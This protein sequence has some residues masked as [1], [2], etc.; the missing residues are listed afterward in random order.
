VKNIMYSGLVALSL[1]LSGCGGGSDEASCRF[2]VQQNLDTGNFDAVITELS[3][4]NSACSNSYVEN[5]LQID[6]GAAYMGQAG[7]GITDIIT[8]LTA[9]SAASSPST[10][11]TLIDK[12]SGAQSDTVLVSLSN[13]KKAYE[14]ALG[15]STCAN[16][17]L[18]SNSQKDICLYIGLGETMRATSTVGYLVDDVTVLFDDTAT[19]AEQDLV[20]EE[21]TASLCALEFYYNS[22]SVCSDASSVI[23]NDVVFTDTNGLTRRFGNITIT[24]AVTGNTYY[25]MGT[26]SGVTPGSTVVTDGYC[27]SNFN[28]QADK[29]GP[30]SPYACPLNKDFNELDLSVEELLVDTL[31][32]GL[33]GITAA[34]SGDDELV[35]DV[36]EYKASIDGV[37]PGV[38]ADGTISIEEV[39]YYLDNDL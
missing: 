8:M 1:A 6:L 37:I 21:L 2:D 35:T 27:D 12:V 3:N 33:D 4:P 34:V 13:A 17:T 32:S 31:N 30:L 39:Q 11:D 38:T 5:D 29:P 10:F 23:A 14:E 25:E 36:V 19:Q 28:N 24:M 26:A 15:I 7:L 18:L 20:K 9:E 22:G 16:P